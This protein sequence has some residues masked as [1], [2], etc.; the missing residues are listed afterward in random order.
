[1]EKW[2]VRKEEHLDEKI[3]DRKLFKDHSSV[4]FQIL[5]FD[6]IPEEL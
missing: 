5:R 2:F 6:Q 1:M 3:K 4:Q